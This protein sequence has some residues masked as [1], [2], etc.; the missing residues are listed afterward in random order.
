VLINCLDTDSVD[1]I[2]VP[3]M[4]KLLLDSEPEVRSEAIEN[5]AALAKF[6]SPSLIIS[7]LI[8][9]L[10]NSIVK[11]GSEHV[12]SSLGINICKIGESLGEEYSTLHIIPIIL[13][14]LKDECSDVR[15]SV[16][17]KIAI[18]INVRYLTIVI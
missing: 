12:R 15:L 11:D 13:S 9:I 14:L 16:L 5:I 1:S 18:I 2:V 8:P 6:G 7:N 4:A 17:S 3:Y 10:K